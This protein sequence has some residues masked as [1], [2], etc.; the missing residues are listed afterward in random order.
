VEDDAAGI[1]CTGDMGGA[2][3]YGLLVFL[4]SR[5]FKLMK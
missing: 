3:Q 5:A 4:S 2:A 1:Q